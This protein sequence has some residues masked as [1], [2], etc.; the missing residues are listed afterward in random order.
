MQRQNLPDAIYGQ[1]DAMELTPSVI[2]HSSSKD[3]EQTSDMKSAAFT[4]QK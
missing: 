3:K 4:D 2:S 1:T